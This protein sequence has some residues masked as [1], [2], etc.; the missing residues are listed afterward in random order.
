[1]LFVILY[2]PFSFGEN[3]NKKIILHHSG[4]QKC[5]PMRVGIKQIYKT[6]LRL[7]ELPAFATVTSE[8]KTCIGDKQRVAEHS[9]IENGLH[10]AHK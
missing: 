10:R 2:E 8:S 9:F 1:M 3:L 4:I 5:Q 7:A 6:N